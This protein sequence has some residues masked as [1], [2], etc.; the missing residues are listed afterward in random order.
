MGK[1]NKRKI[2]MVV[3]SYM[4]LTEGNV[5]H[6]ALRAQDEH[7]ATVLLSFL[8]AEGKK[9]LL[10]FLPS[11][12]TADGFQSRQTAAQLLMPKSALQA[13]VSVPRMPVEQVSLIKSMSTLYFVQKVYF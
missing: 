11:S 1:K 3:F 9:R 7:K 10:F 5:R 6:P 2:H 13:E 12:D 4:S 8:P